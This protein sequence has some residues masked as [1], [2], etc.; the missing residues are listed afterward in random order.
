M[1]NKKI[2]KLIMILT[3][4]AAAVCMSACSVNVNIDTNK[5]N[6]ES[7]RRSNKDNDRDDEEEIESEDEIEENNDEAE[8]NNEPEI[9][10]PVVDEAEDNEESEDVSD[11]TE[12]GISSSFS[13]KDLKGVEFSFSSGAGGWAT[14]LTI[15]KD[16][17][18]SGMYHDS[19]MGD[20]GEG[21][22]NGTVYQCRFEGQFGTLEKVNDYTYKTSIE[23]LEYLDD[24]G[25]EEIADEMKFIYTDVYGLEDANDI[26]FY[27]PG[28]KVS[29]LP[30]DY[31]DWVYWELYDYESGET[32]DKLPF[33]GMYNEAQKEGFSSYDEAENFKKN[34]E[35]YKQYIEDMEK[36]LSEG[37]YPQQPMN[38]KSYEI[39]KA[40]DEQLNSLWSVLTDVL[41]EDEME[42]LREEQRQW[43]KEKEASVEKAGKEFEGGS[44]QPL[45]ENEEASRMTKERIFELMKYLE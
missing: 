1:F 6:E 43:I 4:S 25:T 26:L 13:Y 28:V 31:Q 39:Y 34:F 16:G 32:A 19:D 24:I 11:D 23:S 45:V 30:Q 14:Y 15:D 36:D 22:P 3:I 18:F 10:D 40:W 29:E 33:Y 35:F 17:N 44:M 8:E 7:S 27:M 38:V 41:D 21:Y 42:K 9:K 12:E 20:T 2:K 37:H 5:E